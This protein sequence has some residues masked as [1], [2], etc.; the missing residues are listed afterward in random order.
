MRLFLALQ[1]AD[2]KLFSACPI[3]SLANPVLAKQPPARKKAYKNP[4]DKGQPQH[5]IGAQAGDFL[6]IIK[7]FNM[8]VLQFGEHCLSSFIALKPKPC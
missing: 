7:L 8:P 3:K 1:Q 4:F 2:D 6:N 5:L